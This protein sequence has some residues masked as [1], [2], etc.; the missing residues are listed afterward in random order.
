MKA[1]VRSSPSSFQKKKKYV[2]KNRGIH[3]DFF[4]LLFTEQNQSL[5]LSGYLLSTVKCTSAWNTVS[6]KN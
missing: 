1:R 5:G 4:V 2:D 6:T 3:F